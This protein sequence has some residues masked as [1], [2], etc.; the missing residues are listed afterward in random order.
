MRITAEQADQ[1]LQEDLRL[2]ERAVQR[3]VQVPLNDNQF[4]ALA[5]FVF[6]VG[7]GNLESSTLLRLLNRGW[8]EQVPAQLLR[9]NK[10]NGEMLG[11][12]T[13]RRAA[14]G[15]LWSSQDGLGGGG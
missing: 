3:L 12:L 1:L 7:S 13:R 6:N 4:S 2:V 10:A 11:G 5:S 15:R 8:Y 14:E 9:W